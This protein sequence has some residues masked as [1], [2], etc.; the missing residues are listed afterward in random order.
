MIDVFRTEQRRQVATTERHAH[1]DQF[2][3]APRLARAV[4]GNKGPGEGDG[5]GDGETARS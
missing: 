2:T 3:F 5:D 4:R 1:L